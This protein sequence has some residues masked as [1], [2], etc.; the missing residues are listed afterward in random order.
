MA[1]PSLLAVKWGKRWRSLQKHVQIFK[2][3]IRDVTPQFLLPISLTPNLFPTFIK[4]Q[5]VLDQIKME[6]DDILIEWKS[7][8][9]L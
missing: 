9:L 4:I 2:K 5:T 3:G 7:T 6:I 8:W 1:K